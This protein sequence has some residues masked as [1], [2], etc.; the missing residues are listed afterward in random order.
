VWSLG[1]GAVLGWALGANDASNVFGTAV[2][3]RVVRFRT[4]TL[5]CG[6]FIIL[7]A[8]LEGARGI[9]TL[10]NI[11]SNDIRAAV[12]VSVSAAL[13]LILLTHL[14]LP[15]SA[16]QAVVGAIIG[17]GLTV[18]QPRWDGLAKVVVCWVATPLAAAVAACILF[19]LLGVLMNRMRMS[20]LTRD[21]LLWGGLV[22][23]GAYGSYALGANNVANVTGAYYRTGVVDDPSVLAL[24]GGIFMALGVITYSRRVMLTV[25][26]RLVRL[27]AYAALVVILAEAIT[28]HVFA[29]IGVPVS[30][31]QAV[32]GG[33][34]GVG[35][36]RGASGIQTGVLKSIGLGWILSPLAAAVV[37]SAVY[38]VVA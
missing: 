6:L 10:A 28:V 4:A 2:A 35:F 14:A 3:A 13:V 5:L 7:G 15:I 34:V 23:A 38:R 22:V 9:E 32:I 26:S 17:V 16:S 20:M 27:D 36:M 31:T 18:G 11:S 24:L 33:V 19:M 1:A 25:G 30:T 12:V 8:S 29:W 21:N 37:A